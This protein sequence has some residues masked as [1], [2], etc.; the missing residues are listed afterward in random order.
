MDE[1]EFV[2]ENT[3]VHQEIL[4]IILFLAYCVLIWKETT[5]ILVFCMYLGCTLGRSPFKILGL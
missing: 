4:H 2:E 3:P 1:E 5:L